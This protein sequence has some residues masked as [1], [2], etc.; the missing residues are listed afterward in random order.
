MRLLVNDVRHN[1]SVR[2]NRV[3]DASFADV[4][5]LT[6]VVHRTS[7]DVVP[8]RR[9]IYADDSFQ[10]SLQE[11]DALSASKVPNAAKGIHSSSGGQ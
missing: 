4:P 3:F 8:V 7:E 1:V 11:H 10:V 2:G 6:R 5:N 9:P